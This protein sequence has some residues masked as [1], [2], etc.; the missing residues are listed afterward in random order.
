MWGLGTLFSSPSVGVVALLFVSLVTERGNPHL[1][2]RGGPS[3][4]THT[5]THKTP[6]QPPTRKRLRQHQ[7]SVGRLRAGAGGRDNTARASQTTSP[8]DLSLDPPVHRAP[9]PSLVPRPSPPHPYPLLP[10][11]RQVGRSQSWGMGRGEG[12]VTAEFLPDW[13]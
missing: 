5:D 1:G 9:P 8:S 4:R 7:P 10:H 3:N 11:S 12:D 6:R 13:L 2:G